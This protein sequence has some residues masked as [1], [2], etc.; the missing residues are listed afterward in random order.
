MDPWCLK[1]EIPKLSEHISAAAGDGQNELWKFAGI[2]VTAQ[3]SDAANP[4]DAKL[5]LIMAKLEKLQV[6]VNA[7]DKNASEVSRSRR[8]QIVARGEV[9]SPLLTPQDTVQDLS[10]I[11]NL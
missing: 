8:E 5:D 3:Q 2:A 7:V 6:R 11:F 10:L 1:V 9:M 4:E